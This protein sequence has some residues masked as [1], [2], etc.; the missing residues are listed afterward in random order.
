MRYLAVATVL[1][2]ILAY[3]GQVPETWLILDLP[4]SDVAN[5]LLGMSMVFI[6]ARS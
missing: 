2:G 1:F 6:L 4:F 3:L 5:A